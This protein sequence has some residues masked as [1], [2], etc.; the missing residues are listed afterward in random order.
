M[1]KTIKFAILCSDEKC[2][3]IL[4]QPDGKEVLA[5]DTHARQWDGRGIDRWV[6]GSSV[7]F[8]QH[9]L[10]V[11]VN[12]T[13]ELC[14]IMTAG[15]MASY[16]HYKKNIV[17]WVMTFQGQEYIEPALPEQGDGQFES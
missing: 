1:N 11:L 6:D 16:N 9:S 7:S 2:S 8:A 12:R 3:L 5:V 13:S 14:D 4:F 15:R 17:A 10:A